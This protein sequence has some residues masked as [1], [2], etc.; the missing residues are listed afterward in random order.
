ML[1]DYA[2]RTIKDI[3]RFQIIITKKLCYFDRIRVPL[4]IV[5]I[6]GPLKLSPRAIKSPCRPIFVKRKVQKRNPK[7]IVKKR[8]SNNKQK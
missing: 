3:V 8:G 2:T 1:A 7:D 6:E 4:R 5:F